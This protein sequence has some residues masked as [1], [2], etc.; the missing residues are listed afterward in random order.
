MGCGAL[1]VVASIADHN[2]MWKVDARTVQPKQQLGYYI[3]FGGSS[4]QVRCTTDVDEVALQAKALRHEDRLV[5]YFGGGYGHRNA[6]RFQLIQ[7]LRDSL[8]QARQAT[9]F[10]RVGLSVML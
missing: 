5:L 8:V 10:I 6:C 4:L 9:S 2:R 3:H 1:Y 7:H